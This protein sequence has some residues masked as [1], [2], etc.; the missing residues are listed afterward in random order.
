M[1]GRV[2]RGALEPD[3]TVVVLSGDVPLV[4]AEAIGELVD[5][6]RAGGR[7]RDDGERR[8]SRTPPATGA[9]CGTPTGASSGW[10]RP[11]SEGDATPAEREI[12]E[13]NTG[14]FVF[15]AGALRRRCRG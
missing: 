13:V 11:S 5:A 15:D 14:I 8:S 1:A 2:G 3:A 6:H 10:S 4:S 9:S 12:R 7:R